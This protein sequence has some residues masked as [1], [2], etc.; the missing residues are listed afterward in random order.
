MEMLFPSLVWVFRKNRVGQKNLYSE[1][2]SLLTKQG[3]KKINHGRDDIR[4]PCP[5]KK[6]LSHL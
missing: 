5:V 6:I 3:L 4:K 2:N 1:T